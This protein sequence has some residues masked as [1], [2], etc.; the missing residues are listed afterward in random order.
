MPLAESL[1]DSSNALFDTLQELDRVLQAENNM[2][3]AQTHAK[4]D[5]SHLTLNMHQIAKAANTGRLPVSGERGYW[6]RIEG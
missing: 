5:Q 6:S 2:A 3:I 1:E 4:F